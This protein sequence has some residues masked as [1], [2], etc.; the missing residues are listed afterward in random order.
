MSRVISSSSILPLSS[1]AGGL[2]QSCS[3]TAVRNWLRTL[4]M[5][6]LWNGRRPCRNPM[7]PPLLVVTRTRLGFSPAMPTGAAVYRG[8]RCDSLPTYKFTSLRIIN[9]GHLKKWSLSKITGR[10]V[11][12]YSSQCSHSIYVYIYLPVT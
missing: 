11:P 1:E 6:V 7:C 12:L 10:N 4:F 3:S 5:Y 9:E 8:E 2:K